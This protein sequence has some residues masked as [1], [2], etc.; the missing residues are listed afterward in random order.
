MASSNPQRLQLLSTL[1]RTSPV[2]F[3]LVM[4]LYNIMAPGFNS[5]YLISLVVLSSITNRF[6]KN[7]IMK[8][9]YKLSG[10]ND[11]FLLG[12]GS[13][14]AGAMSC[15]L[16]ID[17]KK[18]T[19]FGMPSGHSQMAWT[20]GTYLI[21]QLFK[22]FSNNLDKQKNIDTSASLIL[23]NIWIFVSA[24]IILSTMIFI[25]YSRVYIEG[26]HTI[27]QVIVGGGIGA[28]IGF[29]AFYFEDDIKRGILG[30]S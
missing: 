13:R 30:H 19:S 10:G 5:F 25:S 15:H 24:L 17:G 27:Q 4:I 23:D 22:R 18:A 8:P 3:Y 1:A 16:V 28:L 12:S 20:I 29:L 6:L 7:V 14:P 9:L 21:C 2:L 26:C 11:I